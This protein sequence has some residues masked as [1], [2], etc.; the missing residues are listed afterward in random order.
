MN[1]W[2]G[3]SCLGIN[4]QHDRL[5]IDNGIERLDK[6]PGVDLPYLVG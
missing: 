4:N 1:E 2:I 6:L 3:R 5:E